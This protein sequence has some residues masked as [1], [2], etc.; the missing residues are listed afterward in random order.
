[1]AIATEMNFQVCVIFTAIQIA[2]CAWW[3][4]AGSTGLEHGLSPPAAQGLSP[5]AARLNRL[6]FIYTSKPGPASRGRLNRPGW[7]PNKG[8][9]IFKTL[10]VMLIAAWVEMQWSW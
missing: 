7:G 8:V 5:L 10:C 3:Y 6:E 2:T 9:Y 4:P 1:M